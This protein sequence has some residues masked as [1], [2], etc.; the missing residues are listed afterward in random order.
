[1]DYEHGKENWF[2]TLENL[3]EMD[4]DIPFD[5]TGE[6]L[7]THELAASCTTV[8]NTYSMFSSIVQDAGDLIEATTEARQH[9]PS[10]VDFA[11]LQPKFAWLP[12]DVIKATF[13]K[14]TQFC[15]CPITG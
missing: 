11:A 9:S 13:D 8:E 6:Y 5:Q 12:T 14:T 10:S 7:H 2:D 4:Y 1:M 15:R 3:P